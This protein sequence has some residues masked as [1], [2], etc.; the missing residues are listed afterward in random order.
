MWGLPLRDPRITHVSDLFDLEGIANNVLVIMFQD[1]EVVKRITPTNHSGDIEVTGGQSFMLIVQQRSAT[2]P[3]SGQGWTNPSGTAAAPSV[4]MRGIEVDDVT[5]ILALRGSITNE[6]RGLRQTDF[7][8]IVKNRSTSR[9]IT[10]VRRG[11]YFDR[12]SNWEADGVGYQLADVDLETGRAASIGDILEVSAQSSHPLISVEP[13]QYTIT[14]EDVRQGWI[15]LPALLAYEIPV[16][17]ALLHN[18][19]NPFNPE[20]WIPYQLAHAADVTLTIYDTQG[21]LVRQL[22]LGYQQAG[23]YTDRIRAAYWDGR[24]EWG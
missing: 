15:R 5:P 12:L 14:V 9:T 6:G 19:P 16:E 4:A 13:L 3:I 10:T 18:Y 7:R 8:V 17:T 20:T 21:V 22:D 2:I 23:Y 11:E 24:N 1:N